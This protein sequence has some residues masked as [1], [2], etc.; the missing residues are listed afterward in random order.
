MDVLD[1][2]DAAAWDAWL[3]THHNDQAEA[4]L[5]IAKR[6]SGLATIAIGDAGDVALC[7][8]WIDGHR[9]GLDDESFLQ[10]YSRRRPRSGEHDEQV[11]DRAHQ[12]RCA[13][14]RAT[15]WPCRA[16]RTVPPRLVDAARARQAVAAEATGHGGT[17][18]WSMP[19]RP[20]MASLASAC[21]PAERTDACPG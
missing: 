21:I 6:N 10:R 12:H 14:H 9:K 13:A 15:R 16:R 5:R 20:A 1:L 17:G 8:G 4:W 3:R 7:Y 11:G 18:C 19:R 2:P